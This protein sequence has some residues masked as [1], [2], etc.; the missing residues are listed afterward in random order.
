MSRV[1]ADS[2]ISLGIG[3]AVPICIGIVVIAPYLLDAVAVVLVDPVL[4]HAL[5]LNQPDVIG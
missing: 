3:R 5:V 2:E 4:D 1:S